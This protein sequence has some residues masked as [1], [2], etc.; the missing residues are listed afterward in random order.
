MVLPQLSCTCHLPL[1]FTSPS[2][3]MHFLIHWYS[4]PLTSQLPPNRTAS[5]CSAFK[6]SPLLSKK[7][8]RA[9][10]ECGLN[11]SLT[12]LPQC[13]IL[14]NV[15]NMIPNCL[16]CHLLFTALMWCIN[17]DLLTDFKATAVIS[18]STACEKG[19]SH[20]SISLTVRHR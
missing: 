18:K 12:S 2:N 11:T 15:T 13:Y 20:S 8:H 16:K 4:I 6:G 10:L 14:Y 7:T 9:T 5:N 1:S 19:N 17:R 3:Q